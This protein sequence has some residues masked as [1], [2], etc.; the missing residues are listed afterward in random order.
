MTKGVKIVSLPIDVNQ[1]R[2]FMCYHVEKWDGKRN[3]WRKHNDAD[4]REIF[5]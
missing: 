2:S 5:S 3:F 1:V 4:P